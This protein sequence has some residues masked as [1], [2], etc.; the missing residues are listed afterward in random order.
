MYRRLWSLI[1]EVHLE[2]R[3]G[4]V[5]RA[6]FK[7]HLLEVNSFLLRNSL[8]LAKEDREL[9]QRYLL[10]LYQVR[11]LSSRV[12]G[13]RMAFALSSIIPPRVAARAAGLVEAQEK[14][15]AV[16]ERLIETIR[17]RLGLDPLR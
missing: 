2:I 8:E 1:E 6:R 11:V 10:L 9:V 5:D 16:R 15:V 14:L 17:M 4:T 3:T 12:P 7:A 13:A